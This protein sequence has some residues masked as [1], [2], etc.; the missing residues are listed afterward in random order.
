[1]DIVFNNKHFS[2]VVVKL[3]QAKAS[4]ITCFELRLPAPG[5]RKP[6]GWTVIT[7]STFFRGWMD[8]NSKKKAIHLN[9]NGFLD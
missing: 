2:L 4:G 3:P 9:M 8:L 6:D 5:L 7:T 1:M